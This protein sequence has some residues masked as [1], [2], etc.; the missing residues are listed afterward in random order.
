MAST[1]EI[2]NKEKKLALFY[3]F[4]ILAFFPNNVFS[5]RFIY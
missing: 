5:L 3:I 4:N 1:D 2:D